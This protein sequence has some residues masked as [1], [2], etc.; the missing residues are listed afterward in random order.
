MLAETAHS[1][2]DTLNQGFLLASLSRG[3]RPADRKHPFGYG[4]ERYF[5]SLLAAFGIFIAGAGFSVFEGL[6]AL[7]RSGGQNPLVGYVVLAIAFVAEGWSLTQ[8][9]GQLRQEA[10]KRQRSVLDH[11]RRSS[12]TT[13]KVA[14][15]EDSAALLG[16]AIAA[17]GLGLREL[18]GSSAWDGA[19][20]II[21][22]VLLV[23]IAFKLGLE[24]KEMLIGRAASR[25]TLSLIRSEI[26]STPGLDELV[27]LLTMHLGPKHM[28]IA[29]RVA[30]SDD[31]TV[32]RAEDLADDIDRR[33]SHRLSVTPHVFIDPT[34]R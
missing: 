22:G 28:I 13:A 31:I 26:E 34:Q 8:A 30:F 5:W 16:L 23:A 6:L 20:S 21:I 11:V 1:V 29:A 25:E 10:R 19:A 14:L 17:A 3:E 27:E 7:G 2:A 9:V 18:T 33:L 4:Q 15:F 32:D 24:S 12:D